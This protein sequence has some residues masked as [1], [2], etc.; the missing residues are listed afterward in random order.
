MNVR[1]YREIGIKFPFTDGP[2]KEGPRASDL[3]TSS[4]LSVSFL[5]SFTNGN[6]VNLKG[7]QEKKVCD[8]MCLYRSLRCIGL[9]TTYTKIFYG[10]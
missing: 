4:T 1:P 10:E 5:T 9:R 3:T 8:K 6:L 7:F 2:V